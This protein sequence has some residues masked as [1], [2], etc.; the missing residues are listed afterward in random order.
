M[1]MLEGFSRYVLELIRVEPAVCTLHYAGNSYHFS[2]GMLMGLQLMAGGIVFWILLGRYS[3]EHRARAAVALPG[4]WQHDHARH[5][6]RSA[7]ERKR[8]VEAGL[9][10]LKLVPLLLVCSV[11]PGLAIVRQ[12]RWSPLEKLC[13]AMGASF[14]LTYLASFTLYCLNAR[15]RCL[16]GRLDSVRIDRLL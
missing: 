8:I 3:S 12:M 7:A 9:L 13:G 2:M 16:L 14:V 5:L 6:P 11:G 1:M 4:S 10:A 15:R